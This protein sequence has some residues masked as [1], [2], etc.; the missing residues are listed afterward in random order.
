MTDKE[1]DE[2]V[3]A[4]LYAFERAEVFYD[5]GRVYAEMKNQSRTL[6]FCLTVGRRQNLFDNCK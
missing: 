5:V 6:K 1:R 3:G 2:L 4:L